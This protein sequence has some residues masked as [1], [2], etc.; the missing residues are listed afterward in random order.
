MV[1]ESCSVQQRAAARSAQQA[2]QQRT[3][4]ARCCA[5]RTG[6]CTLLRAAARCAL[7]MVVDGGGD[8]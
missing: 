4:A 1:P 3:A 7:V 5:L 2:G 8:G 6:H